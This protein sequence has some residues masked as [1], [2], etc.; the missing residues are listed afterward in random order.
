MPSVDND[1]H[2]SSSI[3]T[4]LCDG[5]C[6][7]LAATHPQV[8]FGK[9]SDLYAMLRQAMMARRALLLLDG[10]DEGGQVRGRRG[11]RHVTPPQR[12]VTHPLPKPARHVTHPLPK[13]ACHITHPLPKPARPSAHAPCRARACAQVREEIERHVTSVLAP[14]G[15]VVV[16]TSRPAGLDTRCFE[17]HFWHLRLCAL[18]DKQQLDVIEKRVGTGA[19][20]EALP[21]YLLEKVCDA[22][23]STAFCM[24]LPSFGLPRPFMSLPFV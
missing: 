24:S 19:M 8:E 4:D 23:P 10:I 14:Q 1:C 2:W 17:K 13:P 9:D 20:V 18:S 6:G 5:R 7:T 12:H 3:V 22:L 15:H 21:R 16:V 11:E